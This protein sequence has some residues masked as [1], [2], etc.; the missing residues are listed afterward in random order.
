M[1]DST[2][3]R[4]TWARNPRSV[5]LIERAQ[6]RIPGGVNSP[7]RA[8]RSVGGKPLFLVKGSGCRV[9]DA[10]GHWYIDYVGSWG[11]LITGHA[12]PAVDAAVRAALADGTSFGACTEREIDF[13]ETVCSRV[14]GCDMVRMVSSGTEACMSAI[15]LA[16]GATGRDLIVKFDGC[17]HGHSDG[18]LVAA[19]SGAE[20]LGVPDSPGVPSAIAALTLSLPYNDLDAVR[21]AF[22]M[23]PGGIA[24]VILEPVAGNMGCVP[25]DPGFL[26]GLRSLCT[27]AGT[28]L[29]VD[30][31]MTGFR[32]ARGGAQERFGVVGDLVC[33]GKVIGGGLP[34]AA[35]GGRADL[36]AQMAPTGPVYQ[37]GTLSGNPLAVAAGQAMLDA[38]DDAGVYAQLE[39]TG[40]RLEQGISEAI[41]A[42]GGGA[43]VQRVGAMLGVYFR[44]SAVR[45]LEDARTCDVD[46]FGRV[47][48]ELLAR[49]VY[50]AP[51]AFEAGFVGT[52]HDDAAI[53]ET[54][55][56]WRGALA[57][58]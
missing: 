35:Y 23:H 53:D 19:G 3:S 5:A 17:Y 2:A 10:D 24:A 18:L 46:R 1:S 47:F 44:E 30:E 4:A 58:G 57:A 22:A 45:N 55:E 32:V 50:T 56:A 7:V 27:D 20:T 52:A 29:I 43:R 31:V 28:V 12:S 41:A 40:A 38:L 15:R 39:R 6:R 37:A 26:E 33:L 9:Q 14:P 8:Y 49:G 48:H 51:S 13:A 54:I 16:R 21:A 25:P 36:M 42:T 34:A 11:P